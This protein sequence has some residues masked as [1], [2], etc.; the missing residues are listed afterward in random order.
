MA[1]IV[2][3]PL[4]LLA[5]TSP[6]DRSANLCPNPGFEATS[7]A[8][9]PVK[10]E[11]SPQYT[12]WTDEHVHSGK[13]AAKVFS[14][15]GPTVG[16]TS[17]LIPVRG[18]NWRLAF[19]AWVKT[20]R[21]TGANGAFMALYT[22]GADKK[23]NGQTCMIPIGGAGSEV[24]TSGWK[25]YE[26]SSAELSADVKYVRVNLRL[27]HAA[28]TVYFD[29]VRVTEFEL[30]PLAKPRFIRRRIDVAADAKAVC[31]I[32]ASTDG[33][34]HA[35]EI[36]QAIQ[37]ATGVAVPIVQG[38]ALD[39]ET[40]PRDLILLGNL[41]TNA[42]LEY[43]YL[44]YY[45]YED[46]YFPGAGGHVLRPLYDP[47]GSGSNILVVGASDA[48]GLKSG[49][50]AL[51]D[52]IGKAPKP[53][54]LSLNTQLTVE[55]GRGYRGITAFPWRTSSPPME[56]SPAA[57]YLKSGKWEYAEAYRERVL[58]EWLVPDEELIDSV[59]HLWYRSKTLS[60]DVMDACGV[61]SDDE[62]LALT[63]KLL[64][65]LRSKQGRQY[66]GNRSGLR[67]R[68]NHGIRAARGFYFGWRHFRKYYR[69]S[70]GPELGDWERHMQAFWQSPFASF[71]SF[72]DSLS[73]H[74]FA[75]SLS[76]TLH[77]AFCQREWAR[78]F[79]HGGY[80][81]RMGERCIAV[82]NNRGQ[83]VN[84]GDTGS[85]DYPA[86]VFAMLAYWYR[87]GRYLYLLDKRGAVGSSTDEPFQG[88]RIDLEP[89]EPV[90]HVGV[91][92]VP[93]DEY[94]Y[95]YGLYTL[96]ETRPPPE[97]TFDKL[98][99]RG[100]WDAADD[101]LMLDGTAG[102]S[103]SYDDTNTIGEYSANGR[104]WLCQVDMFNG[105]TMNYHNGLTVARDGFGMSGVP[106]CAELMG[107]AQGKGF[108][109]TATALRH[110]N[111]ID[112]TR[113]ILWL[114]NDCFFVVDEAEATESGDYSLVLRWRGLGEGRFAPGCYEAAQ[115]ERPRATVEIGGTKLLDAATESSGKVLKHLPA[116]DC[117]F[118]R[119]DEAGDFVE[120][121]IDTKRQGSFDASVDVLDYTGR[122]TIQVSLDGRPMGAPIDL[123]YAGAPR[124]RRVTLG[125]L[126]LGE[127]GKHVLRFEVVGKSLLS[128]KHTF[129]VCSFNLHDPQQAVEALA[130]G[131]NRFFLK[132]PRDVPTT[133]DVDREVLGPYVRPSPHHESAINIVEQSVTRALGAG[134]SAAFLNVF[135][136]TAGE[137]A[138]RYELAKLDDR[139][140]LVR[141]PSSV[142]LVGV[143]SRA[144]LGDL[145]VDADCFWVEPQRCVLVGGRAFSF[146]GR[147]L[148]TVCGRASRRGPQAER[149]V[150][151]SPISGSSPSGR[152]LE[153]PSHTHVVEAEIPDPMMGQQM[154]QLLEAQW[155]RAQ[156]GHESESLSAAWAEVPALKD[157]WRVA[158]P[159][160]PLGVTVRRQDKGHTIV[161]TDR[162]GIVT[163]IGSDG[164]SVDTFATG[165]AAHTVACK[166]LDGDGRDEILVGSD[167]ERIYAL[168][169]DLELL[170]KYRVPF[171][172]KE[173]PWMWWTLGTSKVRAVCADDITG[174]GRPEVLAGAGNMR[175][176]VL[177]RTGKPQW[178]YRTDHGTP[179]TIVTADLYNEGKR[180]A[181]VGMGLSASNGYCR[182]LDENG[183][184]LG[185][186]YNDPWCTNLKAIAV[187]DLNHDGTNTIFCG[188][189]RGNLRGYTAAGPTKG[190]ERE[191]AWM[192]NLAGDIRSILL[193]PALAPAE[194]LVVAASDSG[195]LSAFRENGEK[196]W[197]LPLSSA[198][199]RV[200]AIEVEGRPHVVAAC[201]DGKAFVLSATGRLERFFDCGEQLVD[202]APL[203]DGSPDFVGITRTSAWRL[204]AGR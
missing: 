1:T 81:H 143:R 59:L 106:P 144:A 66:A 134:D 164:S 51:I 48:A 47:L 74:A 95:R 145:V 71:R 163:E 170:W 181:V 149:G 2:C 110:Y 182:V 197:G 65:M 53:G 201:K 119:A 116:Y 102:G 151:Q 114:K 57:A 176:H 192:H 168:A 30:Q 33:A 152:P 171:M 185:T 87:D 37:T 156:A 91:H 138:K 63:K 165:A 97:R 177:D 67:S 26:A 204:S 200:V 54:T 99:F 147:D 186:Y 12:E 109:Y 128:D 154:A 118:Y 58:R 203:G 172:R 133:M 111:G 27:Y 18:G 131:S 20:E 72:E 121:A 93:A 120:A 195:Y 191:A 167:D 61:F 68:E 44:R 70:L 113:H 158:I 41:D 88:Y 115:N 157:A 50:E 7:E 89:V 96:R 84:M 60:W 49:V 125:R 198:I 179:T 6:P 180:R 86:T 46:R 117:L 38:A 24:H 28:G 178:H 139:V 55:T 34:D 85:G 196:V 105:P 56:L 160:A 159:G 140:A 15:G 62:R 73:Q 3:S 83:V 108:G 104:I 16:W 69:A 141:S 39:I 137:Q 8:Q 190:V 161:V 98:T 112:W 77:T 100:G 183:A 82:C 103:H 162:A 169:N 35:K 188:N 76:H 5:D 187:G 123:F 75:G 19:T 130:R 10:W 21:V 127:P 79:L 17:D 193:L 155:S 80:L 150:I 40:E 175:F 14:K 45:T 42:A 22:I 78:P 43:L 136:A 32:V 92:I 129:A 146:R 11:A 31:A 142:A 64:V 29:D 148:L 135:Y 126:T 9:R 13:R 23:R 4:L 124:R 166:D 94:Y 132:F 25:R 184:L 36:Q 122:G 202:I 199:M 173:Q 107:C 194:G 101:Y 90:D 189:N 153:R 52:Q 174:D